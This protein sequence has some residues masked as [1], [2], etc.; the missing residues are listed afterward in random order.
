MFFKPSA[1]IITFTLSIFA[2]DNGLIVQTPQGLVN[3]TM[4]FP[5]VRQFLGIPYA[6]AGRW[7]PPSLPPNRTDVFKAIQYGDSCLQSLTPTAIEYLRLAGFDDSA[8][9]VEE[10]ENCLSLNIWTPSIDKKQGVAV[11]LWVYGG[12]FQFGTVELSTL[13]LIS[14]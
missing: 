1:L 7:E 12:G 3:G 13:Y 14:S 6:S 4:I 2:Q 9:F 5:S 11:L 8:I 10:S